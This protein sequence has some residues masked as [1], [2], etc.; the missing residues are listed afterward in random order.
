MDFFLEQYI[1][2]VYD[3]HDGHMQ[4]LAQHARLGLFQEL[5]FRY[6]GSLPNSGRCLQAWGRRHPP[7]SARPLPRE[8]GIYLQSL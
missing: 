6:R 2:A 1:E 8:W 3:F 5:S 7:T 4:H